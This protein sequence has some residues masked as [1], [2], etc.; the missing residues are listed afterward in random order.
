MKGLAICGVLTIIISTSCYRDIDLEAYRSEATVVLNSIIT[1]DTVVM[2]DVSRTWFFTD[3]HPAEDIKDLNVELYINSRLEA[4]MEYNGEK[5]ISD[6]HPQEGDTIKICAKVDG[7]TVTAEDIIPN[8]IELEDVSVSHRKVSSGTPSIEIDGNGNIVEKNKDNEFTYKI[9]FRD[10]ANKKNYYFIRIEECDSRQILGTLDYS[11]DPV[12]QILSE[13]INGSLT[14]RTISGQFGLPFSDEGI[15]G[16]EYVLTIKE[17][18]PDTYYDEGD[19]CYRRFRLYSISKAYYLY[20]VSL[21]S[22]DSDQSWQ[23]GMADIGI[24]EPVP[25]YSNIQGGTG[26]LGCQQQV[27]CLKDIKYLIK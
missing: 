12:F 23:G 4:I 2:V 9:T 6:I 26:I 3:S 21:Q 19:F 16:K 22:N 24:A 7:N 11:Y 8:L 13:Q 17:T 1:P 14:N 20:L 18:G 25:I 27:F 10:E 5:Y 15:D